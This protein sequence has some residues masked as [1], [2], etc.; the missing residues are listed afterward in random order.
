MWEALLLEDRKEGIM[1]GKVLCSV[2]CIVLCWFH[3]PPG[4]YA[5]VTLNFFFFMCVSV[6]T[7]YKYNLPDQPKPPVSFLV[8]VI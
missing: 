1:M 6:V 8:R 4:G 3:L 7:L 5:E 2:W